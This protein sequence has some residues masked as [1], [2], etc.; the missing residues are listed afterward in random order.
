MSSPLAQN[1]VIS[2]GE[3][4]LSHSL[5]G[6]HAA[7]PCSHPCLLCNC[8]AG[9]DNCP[10]PWPL[11]TQKHGATR[12]K[13]DADGPLNKQLQE[14]VG[15][16]LRLHQNEDAAW[17]EAVQE[18]QSTKPVKRSEDRWLTIITERRL[19]FPANEAFLNL[20][21]LVGFVWLFGDWGSYCFNI[22]TTWSFI[23]IIKSHI[24][25]LFKLYHLYPKYLP[26]KLL[27]L[28]SA[29][30]H[31]LYW[32]GGLSRCLLYEAITFDWT[33][34]PAASRVEKMKNA[35]LVTVWPK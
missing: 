6:V 9:P 19:L 24:C 1:K 22:S 5:F 4:S 13:G 21:H 28:H 20:Q 26:L 27:P 32:L 29:T 15:M 8:S 35:K 7:L 3:A 17:V 18:R 10:T 33:C 16:L 30:A 11:C 25:S 31:Q 34:F 14:C 23:I 12:G 2:L